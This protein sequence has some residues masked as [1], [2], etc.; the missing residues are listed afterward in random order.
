M[1]SEDILFLKKHTRKYSGKKCMMHE[2]YSQILKNV[3]IVF[4]GIYMSS[5]RERRGRKKGE[6]DCK[7]VKI[8]IGT[9]G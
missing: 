5:Y 6:R 2:M 4:L 9:S 3:C 7:Q 8:I 1:V